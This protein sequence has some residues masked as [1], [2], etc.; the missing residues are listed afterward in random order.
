MDNE[1][2]LAKQAVL[3]F[4]QAWTS[5]ETQMATG[6][7]GSLHDPVMKQA[8]AT[9]IAVHCTVKKRA[10]VDG[11]L[12]SSKPPTYADV[13]EG[14]IISAALSAPNRAYVDARCTWKLYRFVLHKKR[15]GW[16]IDSI[17]WKVGETDEW[18]N[19]L[20]GM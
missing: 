10:Y 12:T 15:D 16:R 17:K 4:A 18:K 2:K 6:G 7:V 5:W 1:L 13:V 20:I 11:L 19:G 8:H 14:N 9:L 3:R